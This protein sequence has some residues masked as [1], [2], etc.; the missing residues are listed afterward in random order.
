MNPLQQELV[1]K[2]CLAVETVMNP[3]VTQADRLAAHQ[4]CE[5]FK[6]KSSSCI[7][8]G[9]II[10]SKEYPPMIRHFGLQALEHCIKFRWNDLTVHEKLFV[11]SNSLMLLDT[12]TK[13]IIEEEL[14]VK[15]AISRII[16]ELMKREWPQNWPTLMT[17][18]HDAAQHGE[19]QTELVLMVFHRLVEDVVAFQNLPNQ[20]R[21]DILQSLT[22]QLNQLFVFF[23]N[24]LETNSTRYRQL[25][26][27]GNKQESLAVN[28]VSQAVLM[29]LTGFVDWV[30]MSHIVENNGLLLQLLCLLLNESSLQLHSAE[31]LLL[32]VSRKGKLEDR[33]PILILFCEDAM[34]TILTAAIAAEKSSLDEYYYLF[35]KRLCQVLTEIGKQLAVLWGTDP[36][37]VEPPNFSTYLEALLAFTEHESKML[38]SYT[39]TLWALFLRHKHISKNP[40]LI[41]FIPRVVTAATKSLLKVGYPSQND[42]P[43]CAYSKLDFDSDEEFNMFFPRYRSEVADTVRLATLL[44]PKLTFNIAYN[45][46]KSQLQKPLNIGEA[47]VDKG[48]CNLSSPS[49]LEWDALSVFLE[50]VMLRLMASTNAKPETTEGIELL[51]QV[52]A[53]ET[54]DPLILSCLLSCISALFPLLSYTPET[55]PVVLDKIFGSVIFNIPGQTKSTRSRAVKNVRQHACSIIVKICKQY[56]SLIFPAF[57]SLYTHIKHISNDPEQLS[58]MEKT[59]LLEA[60]LLI[61]NEFNNF[62]K[63]SAFIQEILA[64]VR[65]LWM[66]KEFT[67]AFLSPDMFMSYVGLDQ[68]AVEP[69][70]ADTCGINRS[71][72]SYCAHTILGVINRS[73]CPDNLQIAEQ[74]GFV[75]GT[76]TV[77]GQPILRNPATSHILEL[78]HNFIVLL[79]TLNGLWLPEYL[80]LRHP[81]FEKAY[82]LLE[83]D[84]LA[85]LGIPPPCIDNSDS[86]TCKQPLARVKSFLGMIHDNSFHILGNAGQYLGYE[87]Y[88][89][90]NIMNFLNENV[91]C[92]GEYIPDY[93]LRPVIHILEYN[94]HV[95]MKPFIWNCPK[96]FYESAALPMLMKLC[97]FILQRLSTKWQLINTQFQTGSENEEESES[98][99][100][101]EDQLTRQLTREYLELLDYCLTKRSH[102]DNGVG[103]DLNMEENE[104]QKS[105]QNKEMGLNEL[106]QLC[107]KTDALYPSMLFCIFN[108]LS[109]NDTLVCQKCYKLCWPT[110]KQLISDGVMTDE[111]APY[112]FSSVLSGLQ[113]HGQHEGSQANLMNLALQLYEALRP[114]FPVVKS[115]LLQI[116]NVS[117]QAVEIFDDK[118]VQQGPQKQLPEKKKKE[119]LKNLVFEIIGKNVGQQF[120]RE[121]QYKNLPSLF[122]PH[123]RKADSLLNNDSKDIGICSL[124][125]PN[126]D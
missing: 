116:P 19:T 122:K 109:W 38:G 49:F 111:A 7:Q 73:K 50:S 112:V 9:M 71:H 65:E 70:S 1:S 105:N 114:T 28:K 85:I 79:K 21:R 74:G 32:I 61:S 69:S 68:A 78:F 98:Q 54:Q 16:V 103:D 33:K 76:S 107:L 93:R 15:D 47:G 88:A 18:L 82:D 40:T 83:V 34:S 43:S 10:S 14:H 5:E 20:R 39:Q 37:V 24:I 64:P 36:E 123:R 92:Y 2:L 4:I 121:E 11:K 51:E 41:S 89:A 110:V 94:L 26:S 115:V 17:E 29:T 58:Q 66:S 56:P 3:V 81:D 80:R 42:Y 57:D 25:V 30:P 120:K 126:N 124:F 102:S 106:G 104:A 12:G 84:K 46:L 97:P 100:I 52:L 63:Q 45:W 90:S 48:I 31:C 119:A 86:T 55:I 53:Y 23:L 87:F 108:G 77:T 8:V 62:E 118:I 99:E 91:L 125:H 22:A 117:Q 6:D 113:V 75:I 35:L 67:Q 72:I 27:M 96:D 101:I 59:I 13:N 60:I 44:Q 95:F